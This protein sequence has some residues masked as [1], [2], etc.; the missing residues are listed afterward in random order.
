MRV[1][2]VLVSSLL[3]FLFVAVNSLPLRAEVLKIVV[4]DTIQ[5]ATA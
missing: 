3:A 1:R 2:S 4:D 5:A